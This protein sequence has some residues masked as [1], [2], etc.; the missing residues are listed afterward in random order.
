MKIS[1]YHSILVIGVVAIFYTDVSE[2]LHHLDPTNPLLL[3]KNWVIAVS[4]AAIPVL[5]KKGVLGATLRS[6][7]T[8]WCFGYLWIS[9]VWFFFSLQ[10]EGAWGEVRLR[11]LAIIELV[12]FA[13]ILSYPAALQLMRRLLV[14][15]VLCGVALNV[16]ELF[17]PGTFS[18]VFGRSAGLYRNPNLSGEA[19]LVG[20]ILS[21]TVLRSR[22]RTLFVL[23][24]GLGILTTLSR[25]N[26]LAW[27]LA[28]A[29]FIIFGHLRGKDLVLSLLGTFSVGLVLFLPRVDQFLTA[30]ERAGLFNR[31]VLQRL[32]WFTDPFGVSD[33]SSWSRAQVAKEAW[34]KF[35]QAPFFGYGI[36]SSNHAYIEPHNQ[37][38]AFMLDHGLI[39]ALILPLLLVAVSWGAQGEFRKIALIFG[40]VVLVIALGTHTLV[41][42][43]HSLFLFSCMAAMAALRSPART[44]R[45][46]QSDTGQIVAL[47]TTLTTPP[48]GR[49]A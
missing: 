20:M 26:I 19:L 14:V 22:Y 21:T 15:G 9:L 1:W 34:D 6:P 12:V 16:Y 38:L 41:T 35:A 40:G 47:Q 13:V 29:G 32:E 17:V 39:G 43:E 7:L 31:D 46:W 42:Y 44:D 23:V 25:A 4:I 8:L 24:T 30:W 28:V 45:A 18:E 11:I 37:Y 27:G 3:P 48:A 2:F 10:D 36:G 5:L 49:L 33:H